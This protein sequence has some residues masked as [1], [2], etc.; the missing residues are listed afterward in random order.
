MDGKRFINLVLE[1]VQRA[2]VCV[3]VSVS[4]VM[5]TLSTGS[6]THTNT[7]Q[8]L[9]TW[10]PTLKL[11]LFC[12]VWKSV[13]RKGGIMQPNQNILKHQIIDIQRKLQD[14]LRVIKMYEWLLDSY[15]LVSGT[16]ISLVICKKKKEKIW[17]AQK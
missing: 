12:F 9:S 2:S 8:K 17:M 5:Y 7:I 11:F 4:C 13:Y 3:C 14:S 1:C 6:C 16:S 10:F 15:V